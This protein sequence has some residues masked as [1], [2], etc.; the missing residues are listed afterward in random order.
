GTESA[1]EVL[2]RV[3]VRLADLEVHD[4]L[5]LPLERAGAREHIKE[6][7]KRALDAGATHYGPS[8][9]LPELRDAIAK[10]IGETRGV[11]VWADQIRRWRGGRGVGGGGFIALRQAVRDAGLREMQGPRNAIRRVVAERAWEALGPPTTPRAPHV[12]VGRGL[13][14]NLQ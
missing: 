12:R 8:A 9:G 10:H 11:S 4:L 2:G 1:F 7:A 6:A 5:A 13:A 3:E 14:C